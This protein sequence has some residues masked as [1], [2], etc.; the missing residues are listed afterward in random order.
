MLEDSSF[1]VNTIDSDESSSQHLSGC[2][3]MSSTEFRYTEPTDSEVKTI[4]INPHPPRDNS[5]N[6]FY[7]LETKE[8]SRRLTLIM[9]ALMMRSMM[10][11]LEEY[12]TYF[13]KSSFA[14]FHLNKV[15]IPLIAFEI[16]EFLFFEPPILKFGSLTTLLL[17][18]INAQHTQTAIFVISTIIRL[19]EDVVIY[20]VTFV[21]FQFIIS[22]IL[23]ET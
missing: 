21:C 5:V 7:L 14:N 18:R 13:F 17:T 15:F 8:K 22:I 3:S 11:I 12:F 23:K 19:V 10:L 9:M 1:S 6:E 2:E 16:I 20:F 4:Y